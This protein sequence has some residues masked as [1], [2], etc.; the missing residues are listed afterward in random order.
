[1][2]DPA[3]SP[4]E[5]VPDASIIIICHRQV[6]LLRRCL[7]TL[8]NDIDHDIT[9]EV[10][11][12]LNG[13][14]AAADELTTN[15][16][17]GVTVLRTAANIGFPAGC[18]HAATHARGELLVF[19]NDDIEVERGWLRALVDAAAEQPAAGAFGS[20]VVHPAGTLQEAGCILWSDA[21]TAGVGR[22]LRS[23]D[24]GYR[25]R[26]V[27]DYC[28]ACA[29]MV[30]R[31]TWE[32]L[33]GF[34]DSYVLGYYEDVDLCL[35]IREL[36]LDV[37]YEPE[38]VVRH[39]EHASSQTYNM[40]TLLSTI[41]Q[42]RLIEKWGSTL[43]EQEP[44]AD[45]GAAAVQRGLLRARGWPMR[46]L[47][48]DDHVPDT[49]VGAGAGRMFAVVRELAA[50]GYAV[51]VSAQPW[52][53][54]DPLPLGRLG[55]EVIGEDL[56]DHLAR[57]EVIYDV[58]II[59]RPDNLAAA[60]GTVRSCQP[61]ALVA[62]D[63]EALYHLRL[64]RQAD[65]ALDAEPAA[66]VSERAAA[67]RTLESRIGTEVDAIVCVSVKEA[68]WFR[69]CGATCPVE[70]VLP[71]DDDVAFGSP[72]FA[73]RQGLLFVAGWMA[74]ADSPNGDGLR[75][76]ATDV[77]PLI[78]AR[79]PWVRLYVTGANPPQEL[80]WLE[81]PTLQFVG[82][83][84]DLGPVHDTVR[85]AV[86]PIRYGSG[87]KIKTLDAMARGVPVVATSVGAEGIP[88]HGTNAV[89]VA[90]DPADFAEAVLEL[91][92]DR[93]SWEERRESLRDLRSRWKS[94]GR[95]WSSILEDV[96]GTLLTER[97][98]TS[99]RVRGEVVG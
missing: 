57:P 80:R 94:A 46:A 86:V 62:Y 36:G 58:V 54:G 30:R 24:G 63:A 59:S 8:R 16:V 28:S 65:L 48:I 47:V 11:V 78:E 60:L 77:L 12:L 88:L 7:A 93:L 89:A 74:G 64:E 5:S 19:L 72:G 10:I 43:S 22:G 14:G 18:N 99:A 53:G 96:C 51:A 42:A 35:R 40:T 75:W 73:D 84:P 50:A 61:Q 91:L 68:E 27:V 44:R 98:P 33:R 83:I 4:V 26:R 37:M 15:D 45:G 6:G 95:S 55:I 87:V 70:V 20:R 69:A 97:V 90:D 38:A 21:T 1:M 92:D 13:T 23:D 52:G 31:W 41:N 2:R 34:D 76:F 25:Y 29:L 81:S 66:S 67:M 32:A 17:R 56:A 49:H 3:T 79:L 39:R 85:A 71:F 82:D 9:T